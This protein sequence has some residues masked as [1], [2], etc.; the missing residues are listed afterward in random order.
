MGKAITNK[1]APAKSLKAHRTIAKDPKQTGKMDVKKMV[2]GEQFSNSQYMKVI[3]ISSEY[4]EL[5]TS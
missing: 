2:M 1:T 3:G 5:L 4:V